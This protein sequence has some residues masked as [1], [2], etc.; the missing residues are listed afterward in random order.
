MKWYAEITEWTGAQ[1]PNHVYLLN[2]SKSKMYAYQPWG[3]GAVKVFKNAI[4]IDLR[5]RK[6][7]INPVQ[8]QVTVEKEKPQGRTWTVQGSRGDQY[9]VSEQHGEWA[10]TCSGFKFRGQCRHITDTQQSQ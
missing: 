8:H 2:D 3:Q 4:G 5:G 6:F 1:T 10:C 9:T 7:K